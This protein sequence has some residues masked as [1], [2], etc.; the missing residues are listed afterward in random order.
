MEID[1][2][3]GES[4]PKT[5]EAEGGLGEDKKKKH[6]LR[7]HIPHRLAFKGPLKRF[8]KEDSHTP[9]SSEANDSLKMPTPWTSLSTA[10]RAEPRVLHGYTLTKE[11][12]FRDVCL[13]IK[14]AAF[15]NRS[16][17]SQKLLLSRLFADTVISRS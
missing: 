14:D 10:T 15:V 9:A 11:V 8:L 7:S 5:E 1:V 17:N 16:V 13:A 4:K 6:G 2:W 12:P 3:N